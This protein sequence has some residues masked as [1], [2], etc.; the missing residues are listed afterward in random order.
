MSHLPPGCWQGQRS[1]WAHAHDTAFLQCRMAI[2]GS[3]RVAQVLADDVDFHCFL[4]TNFGKGQIK[5]CRTS[6]DA[7]IQIALQ[8]AHFHVSC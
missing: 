6:P 5:R 7:F 8:L 2:D 3:Y 1:L 4:F